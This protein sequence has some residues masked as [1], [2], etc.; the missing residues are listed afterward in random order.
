[1]GGATANYQEWSPEEDDRLRQA[2]A[3]GERIDL[4]A[5]ELHRTPLAARS[6]AEKIGLAGTHAAGR[7]GWATEPDWT[8]DE[9]ATLRAHYGKVPTPELAERLGRSKAGLYNRAW[10]LG[11]EHGYHRI[12]SR[13][14]RKALQI[15]FD[16][17]LAITDLAAALG[18][19][20]F[21][22]SKYATNHDYD[23]GRRSLRQKPLSLD[24]ILALADPAVAC[25]PARRQP[26]PKLRAAPKPEQRPSGKNPNPR[27][28]N[29]YSAERKEQFL[30]AL[31][32]RRTV[33]GAMTALNLHAGSDTWYRRA[34]ELDPAFA[35]A[36]DA[37][38]PGT[39]SSWADPDRQRRLVDALRSYGTIIGALEHIG[40]TKG[41]ATNLRTAWGRM[42]EFHQR[43]QE[44]IAAH[45][46]AQPAREA[47]PPAPRQARRPG[48]IVG[49]FNVANPVL[50]TVTLPPRRRK[51]DAEIAA[52]T[53]RHIEERKRFEAL[54]RAPTILTIEEAKRIV[55]RRGPVY[56]A[57]L[58]GGREGEWVVGTRTLTDEQ[59]VA[60]AQRVRA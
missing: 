18:R 29:A 26:T 30:E 13:D 33:S 41:S 38:L 37:M 19:K 24:D 6:R 9:D 27:T 49:V 22:V 47:P 50:G 31:R 2:Y 57:S 58:V 40:L 51:S 15:A 5:G 48:R 44:A 10:T 1:M 46:A 4:V 35:A 59:L 42:P 20:A 52:E 54:E 53:L 43:C 8:E 16:R 11:L 17:G 34:R 25:P 3:N 39:R 23:F 32:A 55:Q 56:R 36:C 7:G 14:E 21:S 28:L 12:W 60:E 45:R